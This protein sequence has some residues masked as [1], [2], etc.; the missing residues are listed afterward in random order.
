MEDKV[1]DYLD[2]MDGLT[3]EDIL[4]GNI[5]LKTPRKNLETN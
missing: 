1:N 2:K 3:V 5:L 4:D